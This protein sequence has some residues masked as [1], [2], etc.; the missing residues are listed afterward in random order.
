MR[1]RDFDKTANAIGE[2][3]VRKMGGSFLDENNVVWKDIDGKWIGKRS[4]CTFDFRG[5]WREDTTL[6]NIKSWWCGGEYA[7]YKEVFYREEI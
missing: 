7:D 4:V 2:A 3:I 5:C 6:E 1:E